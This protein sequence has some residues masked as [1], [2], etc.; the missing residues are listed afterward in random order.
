MDRVYKNMGEK[1]VLFEKRGPLGMITL[2][3][4]GQKNALTAQMA[5]ELAEIRKRIGWDSGITLF[6]ITGRGSDFSIG[7]DPEAFQLFERREDLINHLSMASFVG[8]LTQPTVAVL[9]GD[10]FGQGLE[11]AL[12]SDIRIASEQ[13]RFSMSQINIREMPFDGGTQR[14]PRLVGRTKAMEMILTGQTVDAREAKEIG[15]VNHIVRSDELMPAA[16]KLAEDLSLKGP[17]ALRY[18]KEAVIKGMDMTLAQGLRLEADL[19]FLLQTT[20]DRREGIT[21]FREKRRPKFEG[22]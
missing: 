18:V 14:L 4:P 20:K 2:N 10:T 16:L 5:S 19:Y 7:T 1:K 21:A 12:A 9:Q 6:L 17:V 3:R 13:S 11:L 8:S 22:K 15:L